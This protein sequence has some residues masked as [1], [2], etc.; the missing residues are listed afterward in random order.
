MMVV[1][2]ADLSIGML[3]I[4]LFTFDQRWLGKKK[5]GVTVL[6]DGE[7]GLCSKAMR[8]IAEEDSM[9][10][11]KLRSLQEPAGQ[12]LLEKYNL[13]KE[14]FDTMVFIKKDEAFIKSD[15]AI[16]IGESLGGLWRLGIIGKYIPK[17][18]RNKLYDW[19]SRNRLSFF[20]KAD[21]CRIPP[22]KLR[23]KLI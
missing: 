19:V 12:S 1:S 11:F 8:F 16:G 23:K 21:V 22:V 3:M 17:E 7:C 6:Y 20:G 14:H 18:L 9:N 5:E 15:A 13:P 2:F 10:N 4:H